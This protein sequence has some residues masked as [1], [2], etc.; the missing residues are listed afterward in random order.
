MICIFV[1]FLKNQLAFINVRISFICMNSD[2]YNFEYP[3][4]K[5]LIV[6][7]HKLKIKFFI[8]YC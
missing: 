6:I 7:N 8:S 1:Y 2:K 5:Y 4:L 3:I